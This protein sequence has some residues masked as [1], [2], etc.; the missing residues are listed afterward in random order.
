MN[1]APS[2]PKAAVAGTSDGKVWFSENIHTGASC[3]Q[4]AAN[5][6]SFSCT[7]NTS[8]T[9]RDADSTNAVLPNRAILGVAH[10]PTNHR[11]IYAA[12]GGFDDN[13]PATPGHLFQLTWNGT[14]WTRANKTG[15]LPDVPAAAVV[16]NPLN[17]K[18]VFV[19][20]FFGF[21]FTDDIDA[22]TPVWARYQWGLPNTVIQY[23]TVDRG[24]AATPFAGTTLMAFT[25]GRGVYAIRLPTGGASFPIH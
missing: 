16:V 21:Y 1:L 22:A 15:N 14:A 11:A 24:P 13:T 20:T 10:D 19:G 18:Q 23:L 12:V 8:A 9:W 7:P 25:Y 4:A 2:E 5:T 17:R 3:T 6:A